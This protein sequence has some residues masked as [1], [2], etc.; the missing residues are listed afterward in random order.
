MSVKRKNLLIVFG[1]LFLMFVGFY[2]IDNEFIK[3]LGNDN[4]DKLII[5]WAST[6]TFAIPGILAIYEVF[7]HRKIESLRVYKIALSVFLIVSYLLYM[8]L[9]DAIGVYFFYHVVVS[10]IPVYLV[11]KERG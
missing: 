3:Y 11:T 6:F 2:I 10:L 7:N 9:F 1:L 5:Q 8:F 4:K